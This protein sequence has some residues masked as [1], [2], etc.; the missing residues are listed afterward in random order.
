MNRC[1]CL[2]AI[3]AIAAAPL[4][5]EELLVRDLRLGVAVMPT[6]F[7]Y[8][9]TAPLATASGSDRLDRAEALGLRASWSWSGAGRSWAPILATEVIAEQA[10]YGA[11]GRFSQFG[12]RG[13]GGIGWQPGDDW[14]LTALAL[15]GAGR[16][17]FSVPIASG[18]ALDTAGASASTGLLLGLGYAFSRA[19]S[20][21]VEAG[22]I[23]EHA[24]LSGDGVNLDL[25]RSGF[26][27]GVGISW[28][29]SRRPIRL[30]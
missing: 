18:G 23:E 22:W 11:G 1:T 20:V 5:A 25:A 21:G 30:E 27:A 10:S 2:V 28:A 7:T 8:T 26:T 14:T 3:L 16:P 9:T 4:P 13:L 17:S 24:A 6:S 29:W 15:L 19:W 12:L